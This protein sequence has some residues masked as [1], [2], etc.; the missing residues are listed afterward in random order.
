ME[1]FT[2]FWVIEDNSDE[3]AWK[4]TDIWSADT[5]SGKVAGIS[6]TKFKNSLNSLGRSNTK[7]WSWTY[8]NGIN[9]INMAAPTIINTANDRINAID[10][11]T[12]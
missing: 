8:I 9:Q 3:T 12:L 10:S 5:R 11:E 1:D 6:D 7:V 4:N 2:R